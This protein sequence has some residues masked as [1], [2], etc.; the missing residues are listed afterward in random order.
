MNN[1][2]LLTTEYQDLWRSQRSVDSSTN[3]LGKGSTQ[4]EPVPNP[5][6]NL[7]LE[8]VPNPNP[9]LNLEAAKVTAGKEKPET[10]P[11][12]VTIDGRVDTDIDHLIDDLND[13]Q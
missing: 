6:P 12:I 10:Y 8:S 7:N 5:N 4:A 3:Y 13:G 1:C 11:P 2:V 9:N